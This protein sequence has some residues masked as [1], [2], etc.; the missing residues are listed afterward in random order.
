MK[1]LFFFAVLAVAVT[2][3][4]MQMGTAHAQ[5]TPNNAALLQQLQ[6]AKATLLNLEM[7]QG[8]I[9]Q[10]DDQLTA[11]SPAIAQ[12]SAPAASGLSPAEAAYFNGVLSQLAGSLR[13]LA[14]TVNAN[15]SMDSTQTAAIAAT[16]GG[17]RGTLLTMA[18]QIAQ[19]ENRSPI[20]AATPSAGTV[21][22]ASTVAPSQVAQ[23]PPATTP[24]A[25]ANTPA[26]TTP[27]AAP[28]T[29]NVQATAQASSIWSFTK[30]NWPVIVIIV[31]VIAILAILFWP[32]NETKESV[33]TVNISTPKVTATA[34]SGAGTNS[35]SASAS[36]PVDPNTIRTA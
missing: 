32:E 35:V 17:M 30:A 34:T 18:T 36:S 22:G 21:A 31:L 6:V 15:P 5:A 33:K 20:A 4:G 10:S 28:A 9:P 27:P 24:S 19:D 3:F 25:A 1:K 11:G 29:N 12:P 26:A 23:T 16:L 2:G 13:Q 14:A 8:L 7:Q